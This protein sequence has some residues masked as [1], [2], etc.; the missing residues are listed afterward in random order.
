MPVLMLTGF[1]VLD[2]ASADNDRKLLEMIRADRELLG[3][4]H[5]DAVEWF[6]DA[7]EARLVRSFIA[8]SLEEPAFIYSPT[9]GD[10]VPDSH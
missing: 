3:L 8:S 9:L 10:T 6:N 4:P 5:I 1:L 7:E 2:K